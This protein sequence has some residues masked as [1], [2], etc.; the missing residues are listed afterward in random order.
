MYKI[1]EAFASFTSI[2]GPHWGTPVSDF[3]SEDIPDMFQPLVYGTLNILLGDLI[4]FLSGHPEFYG[5]QDSAACVAHFTIDGITAFNTTYPCLGVPSGNTRGTYGSDAT[6]PGKIKGDGRGGDG[7]IL[8][9]SWTG[10]VFQSGKRTSP[11][12]NLFDPLDLA[13][14]LTD[15]M[16][17]GYNNFH[18]PSDGFIP[19]SSAHFGQVLCD[20]YLWNHFDE[21]NQTLGLIHP[22]AANPV[23]VFR[24]HA[25]RLQKAGL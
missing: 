20:T 14:L 7:D 8:Y 19:V 10:D 5:T 1:P 23:A 11:A 22:D 17:K 18:S 6:I 9:Y 2:A 12:T 4:S 13:I 25:N 16:G 21:I 15:S 24:Q 3:I